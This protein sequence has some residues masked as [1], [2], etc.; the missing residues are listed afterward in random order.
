MIN[1]KVKKSKIMEEL[2]DRRYYKKPS[3]AKR[4]KRRRAKR[5][6][7]KELRKQQAAMRSEKNR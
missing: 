5:A 2:R 7:E 4:E 6:R 3:D 1:K